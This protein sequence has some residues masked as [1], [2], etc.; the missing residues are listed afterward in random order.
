MQSD[1]NQIY[2]LTS[3]RT[4]ESEHIYKDIGNFIFAELNAV[5]RKPSSLIIKLK[6]V[7]SWY[8]RK[9]R[10]QIILEQYPMDITREKEEFTSEYTYKNYCE[11]RDRHLI[12]AQRMIEYEDYIRRKKEIRK[13]RYESQVLLQPNK[14]EDECSES[15]SS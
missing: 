7:G 12:F 3:A 14:G 13:I 11:R 6:G 8:L 2:K 5:M 4:G 9:K 10:M 1:N 15:S